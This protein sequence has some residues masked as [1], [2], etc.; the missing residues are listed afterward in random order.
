[1]RRVVELRSVYSLR[2]F[3]ALRA[4]KRELWSHYTASANKQSGARKCELRLCYTRALLA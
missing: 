1:M 3:I 2:Q 4:F